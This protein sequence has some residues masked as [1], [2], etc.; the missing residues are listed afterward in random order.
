MKSATRKAASESAA[1][2]DSRSASR[3]VSASLRLQGPASGMGVLPG[4]GNIDGFQGVQD[5]FEPG[6]YRVVF[7][8]IETDEGKGAQAEGQEGGDHLHQGVKLGASPPVD[9]SQ[10]EISQ[11]KGD[12]QR[13]VG[14]RPF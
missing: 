10:E 12:S 14:Q 2:A 4:V 8:V 13:Q 3:Y 6:P 11:E 9:I 7:L 5:L 1:S